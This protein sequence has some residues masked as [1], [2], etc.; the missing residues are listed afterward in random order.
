MLLLSQTVRQDD[1]HLN[2]LILHLREK[3]CQIIAEASLV[4]VV[5]SPVVEVA[6]LAVSHIVVW[7]V[8]DIDTAAHL[9]DKCQVE[10]VDTLDHRIDKAGWIAGIAGVLVDLS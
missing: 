9:P 6:F 2:T 1:T 4:A 3:R 8:V 7:A 10:M 5:G